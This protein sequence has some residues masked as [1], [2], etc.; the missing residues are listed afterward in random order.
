MAKINLDR[1]MYDWAES[2]ARQAAEIDGWTR[3][4]ELL[5][6]EIH[7]YKGEFEPAIRLLRRLLETDPKNEQISKL[8]EIARQLP[9]QQAEEKILAS[10]PPMDEPTLVSGL[11]QADE[12]PPAPSKLTEDDVLDQSIGIPGV[13]G[14]LFVNRDGLL[15]SSRWSLEGSAEKFA[16]EM[17]EISG[18]LGRELALDCWGEVTTVLVESEDRTFYLVRRLKAMFV[19]VVGDAANLGGLRMRLESLLSRLPQ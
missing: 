11:A 12:A 6:A 15:V 3:S 9:Q 18:L 1:R 2:E 14:V 16:A 13:D 5:L 7:I 8:L 10:Q 19:F 4:T 17:T